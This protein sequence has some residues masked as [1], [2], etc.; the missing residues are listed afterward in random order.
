MPY[1][2]GVPPYGVSYVGVVLVSACCLSGAWRVRPS[3]VGYVYRGGPIL[4]ELRL[5][6]GRSAA[7][8][9]SSQQGWPGSQNLACSLS[10]VQT[11]PHL[12][13]VCT[14]PT[15][16]SS[17]RMS[18]HTAYVPVAFPLLAP[19]GYPVC[20]TPCLCYYQWTGVRFGRSY[21]CVVAYYG[22]YHATSDAAAPCVADGA[23][24]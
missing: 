4:F 14:S 19:R 18:G 3:F 10:P 13:H 16:S 11:Y 20:C 23:G 17:T 8:A 24:L 22:T 15:L 12:A 1:G 6:H 7:R 2:T 5:C 21:V 9:Y